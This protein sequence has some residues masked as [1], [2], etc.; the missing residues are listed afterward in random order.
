[1]GWLPNRPPTMSNQSETLKHQLAAL[2]N[3]SDSPDL[4]FDAPHSRTAQEL[5]ARLEDCQTYLAHLKDEKEHHTLLDYDTAEKI[6]RSLQVLAADFNKL[7]PEQATAIY[8][9]MEYFIC[10]E[11][12]ENDLSSS[13]GFDDDAEIL[14]QVLRFIGRKDLH[15]EPG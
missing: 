10:S 6:V 3:S 12:E 4:P 15:V 8:L 9:A 5:A 1:M 14:N 13:I 7:P 2:L 11:D